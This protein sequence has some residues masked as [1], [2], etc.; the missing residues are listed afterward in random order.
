MTSV[1]CLSNVWSKPTPGWETTWLGMTV[2][3]EAVSPATSHRC[4]HASSPSRGCSVAQWLMVACFRPLQAP[5]AAV[6][7]DA[8]PALI[9]P[10][11][12]GAREPSSDEEWQQ[13]RRRRVSSSVARSGRSTPLPFEFE[14]A[15][16][17]S[18]GDHLR[19]TAS[20]SA[21][22]RASASQL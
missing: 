15:T 3:C 18:R 1:R 2:L 8:S 16:A 6:D 20:S 10:A 11:D 21:G 12:A 4:V 5:A 7:L 9:E 13:H 14:S 22:A 19:E 17:A